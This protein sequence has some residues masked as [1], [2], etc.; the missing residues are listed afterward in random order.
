MSLNLLYAWWVLYI[1]VKEKKN[2]PK[3][4]WALAGSIITAVGATGI[5]VLVYFLDSEQLNIL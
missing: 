2:I 3:Y 5:L 4:R 1:T